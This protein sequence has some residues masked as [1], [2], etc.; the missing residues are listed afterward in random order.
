MLNLAIIAPGGYFLDGSYGISEAGFPLPL[1]A[2]F[3]VELMPNV[4]EFL[5]AW[6]QHSGR[7]SHGF[8]LQFVRDHTSQSQ[9]D[10]VV[11]GAFIR[12]MKGRVSLARPAY[13][14]LAS[15]ET[16]E[17]LLSVH[18]TPSEDRGSFE[19]SGFLSLGPALYY[20]FEG[21]AIPTESRSALSNVVAISGGKAA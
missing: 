4:V 19:V 21:R 3:N 13:E 1:Q 6:Q 7:P 18:F 2:R 9:A 16:R 15:D 11:S 8:K 5:G 20:A 12:S 17:H 10:V 14:I